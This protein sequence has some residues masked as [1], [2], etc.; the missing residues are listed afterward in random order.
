MDTLNGLGLLDT[1]LPEI[2]PI[3]RVEAARLT[4]EAERH[5]A[6]R[7][8]LDGRSLAMRLIDSLREQ[9]TDE[10]LWIE[11]NSEDRVPMLMVHPLDRLEAQYVY[12]RGPAADF[13]AH[14]SFG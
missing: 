3:S 9:L 1:Y 10:I 12:S 4:L 13:R 8:S 5:L 14:R 7:E 11:T 6:L 2:R